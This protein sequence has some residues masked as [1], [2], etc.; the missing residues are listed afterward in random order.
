[1]AD[2]KRVSGMRSRRE[3]AGLT[4]DTGLTPGQTRDIGTSR[5]RRPVSPRLPD[6]GEGHR[7]IITENDVQ[8][9]RGR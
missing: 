6:L 4:F 3:R 5:L 8:I 9:T 7:V 2:L 1:M